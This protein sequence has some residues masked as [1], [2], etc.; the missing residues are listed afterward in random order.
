VKILEASLNNEVLNIKLLTVTGL[1][2]KIFHWA[3]LKEVL[4][5]SLQF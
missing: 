1:S 2:G 3:I 4:S 5:S